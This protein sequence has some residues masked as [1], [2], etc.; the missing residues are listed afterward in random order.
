MPTDDKSDLALNLLK[1][2]ANRGHSSEGNE[3]Y[4]FRYG[5]TALKLRPDLIG[6]TRLNV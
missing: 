3:K 1:I 6:L 4:T 2:E 5:P